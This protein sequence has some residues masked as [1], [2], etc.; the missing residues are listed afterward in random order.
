MTPDLSQQVLRT[1]V[2]GMPMEWIGYQE[3]VRLACLEQVSYSLGP[4]LY[5]IHGGYCSRTGRR[6]VID[7]NAIIATHGTNPT[8]S[9]HGTHYTPP[10]S[11][12]ALFK[13]DQHLCLYC[14]LQFRA[15]E[16]SRDH[17]RPISQGGQVTGWRK[18]A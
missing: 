1:D 17:V 14:G 10:L 5:R 9:N 2:A 8:L 3:A 7:I 12:R 6:S 4:I 16:L 18:A 13:R 15:N 11:N